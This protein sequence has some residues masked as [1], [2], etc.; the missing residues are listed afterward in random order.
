MSESSYHKY[1]DVALMRS[2][3]YGSDPEFFDE[4]I[5]ELKQRGLWDKAEEFLDRVDAELVEL[6][7]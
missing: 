2:Y 6:V 1:Q 4:L 7:K 3:V 5:D